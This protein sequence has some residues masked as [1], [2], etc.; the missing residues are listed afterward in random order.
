MQNLVVIVGG[1]AGESRAGALGDSHV[2]PGGNLQ[3]LRILRIG[4]QDI[5]VI[6]AGRS[7]AWFWDIVLDVFVQQALYQCMVTSGIEL[8][9]TATPA[10]ASIEQFWL[11][12]EVEAFNVAKVYQQGMPAAS[13]VVRCAGGRF[14]WREVV[15]H[16]WLIALMYLGA[17]FTLDELSHHV[18]HRCLFVAVEERRRIVDDKDPIVVAIF[19]VDFQSEILARTIEPRAHGFVQR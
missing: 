8:G 9:W 3:S 14:G 17:L 19:T 11:D 5:N 16:G 1:H 6:Q 7:A 2:T 12:D 18:E 4:M 15:T 10:E 13:F